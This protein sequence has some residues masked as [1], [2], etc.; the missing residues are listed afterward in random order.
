MNAMQPYIRG[1]EAVD[2]HIPQGEYRIRQECLGQVPPHSVQIDR[3]EY[4]YGPLASTHGFLAR[5]DLQCGIH[6]PVVGFLLFPNL[7]RGVL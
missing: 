1:H 2:H 6:A 4:V 3:R 5:E 7:L